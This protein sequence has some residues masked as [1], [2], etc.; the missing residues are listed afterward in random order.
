[1]PLVGLRGLML[2]EAEKQQGPVADNSMNLV[3]TRRL[4]FS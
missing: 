4:C 2:I 3:F 1:M